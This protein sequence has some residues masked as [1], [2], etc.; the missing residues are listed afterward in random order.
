MGHQGFRAILLYF[1]LFL[2][3]IIIGFCLKNNVF[4]SITCIN[5]L[6]LFLQ[7]IEIFNKVEILECQATYESYLLDIL[8]HSKVNNMTP[9]LVEY[10]EQKIDENDSQSI[11]TDNFE[12]FEG[13]KKFM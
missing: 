8:N 7:L 12:R 4:I 5:G 11:M 3:N 2:I 10:I 9:K 6:L 1:C 13:L